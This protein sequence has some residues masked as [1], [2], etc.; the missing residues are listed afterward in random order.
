MYEINYLVADKE[1][2]ITLLRVCNIF[3]GKNFLRGGPIF[4]KILPTDTKKAAT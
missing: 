3:V 2:K 1:L 4:P